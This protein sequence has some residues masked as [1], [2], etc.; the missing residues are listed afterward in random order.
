MISPIIVSIKKV[1]PSIGCQ[2]CTR[3]ISEGENIRSGRWW[4]EQPEQKECGLH[5]V[6]G[7]LVRKN[8]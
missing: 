8:S 2:P 3:A 6:D 7:K 4:W 1:S 5:M